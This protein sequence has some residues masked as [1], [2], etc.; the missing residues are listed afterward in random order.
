MEKSNDPKFTRW[1]DQYMVATSGW[2]HAKT[3]SRRR[4]YMA[5]VRKLQREFC[6]TRNQPLT[7]FPMYQNQ[8]QGDL[9]L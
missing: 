2:V 1:F 5:E 3:P 8:V 9:G 7:V 6:R 4:V